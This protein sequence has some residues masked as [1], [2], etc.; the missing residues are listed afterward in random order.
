[1]VKTKKNKQT[2][3]YQEVLAQLD[4]A[5]AEMP[6]NPKVFQLE[7]V[8]KESFSHL[9]EASLN[10]TDF[11]VGDVVTGRVV[12]L[13]D[14]YVVVDIGYKSEGLIPI[15]EFRMVDGQTGVEVGQ[16]VQVYIDRIENENGMMVLSKDKADMLRVWDDIS[17][18]ADSQKIIEGTI[19]AKVKGGLSVD[20]GVKAFL[21]G[22]Q[23]DVRP[24]WD[25]DQLVGQKCQFKVIKFNKRR[26]NIVLSRRAVLEQERKSLRS[27]TLW[28]MEEGSVVKGVIKNI[29][30]YG[31]FVDLGGMDGLLHITDMSWGRINHPSEILSSGQEIE[32]KI[33]KFDHDKERVSLGL[34]QLKEDPWNLAVSHY[35]RGKKVQGKV[36]GLVDYGAF[37]ELEDGVEGLIHVSEMSWTKKIKNPSQMVKVGDVVDV[38]V[39][40]VDPENR[41]ISLGIKQLEDNPWVALKEAY[42]EGTILEGNIKSIADFGVFVGVQEGLDGLV[43]VSDLS[44]AQKE[45]KPTEMFKKGDSL[46]VVVLGVDVEN[47]KLSLGV[48]QLEPDPWANIEDKYPI[49]SQH[50]VKVVGLVDFG[51]FVELDKNVEGLIHISELSQKRTKNVQDVVKVGDMIKAEIVAVD[52]DSR[53]ISLSVKLV[54]LR[55]QQVD[56]G[57]HLKKARASSKANLGDVLGDVL[58]QVESVS[59]KEKKEEKKDKEEKKTEVQTSSQEESS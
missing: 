47:E 9:Y 7:D 40:G 17:K 30:E 1:M 42:P 33:L 56:M 39:L 25:M 36:V 48:K 32:V 12:E 19:I 34:K 20:I 4:L 45:V 5:D 27:Q 49:G 58:N 26:G 31:A 24:V 28:S 18:A 50:E 57:E 44:W 43:H 8:S 54:A 55:E 23:I 6:Q 29:T 35:E 15:S 2:A 52:K 38:V 11:R 22:S 21:P 14:S 16:E 51:V 59:L 10:K 53:K 13:Q 46:K 37:V 41:R 3:A